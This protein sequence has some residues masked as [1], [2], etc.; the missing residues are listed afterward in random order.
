MNHCHWQ[1]SAKDQ[2]G[3][4]LTPATSQEPFFFFFLSFPLLFNK[5]T[6][7]DPRPETDL[8]SSHQAGPEACDR[9]RFERDEPESH[10]TSFLLGGSMH[11]NHC[12][13]LSLPLKTS[14]VADSGL[15]GPRQGSIILE[16]SMSCIRHLAPL[17]VMYSTSTCPPRNTEWAQSLIS[18]WEPCALSNV[19]PAHPEDFPRCFAHLT[20]ELVHDNT[21]SILAP[22][23]EFGNDCGLARLADTSDSP[24]GRGAEQ[25]KVLAAVERAVL[26]ISISRL[27][28]LVPQIHVPS[29]SRLELLFHFVRPCC[30]AFCPRYPLFGTFVIVNL[31]P[32]PMPSRY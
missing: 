8:G 21:K 15:Q 30:E 24:I 32:Q 26:L 10:A 12:R 5:H 2:Q 27:P 1:G 20:W 22:T 31:Q 7:Q 9:R 16:D 23:A 28:L 6:I 14:Q 4:P 11:V 19:F 18:P 13:P 25:W 3:I 29:A 17:V